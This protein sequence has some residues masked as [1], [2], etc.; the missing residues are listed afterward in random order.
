MVTSIEHNLGKI[1]ILVNNAGI[2]RACTIDTILERDWEDLLRTNLTASFLVAQALLPSMRR[3]KWGRIINISSVAAQVGGVVGPHYAA[4][5]AG[6]IGLTHY[7]AAHLAKE[8]ITVNAIS[9]GPIRTDMAKVLGLTESAIPLGRL[10]TPEEI[11]AIAVLLA[12]NGYITGQTI[13][14]NGGR[15]LD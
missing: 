6:I 4:S 8:G 2:A 9:P 12:E 15:Y 7:Y 1:D 11:A 10:G 5:K 13:N 3:K 14:V